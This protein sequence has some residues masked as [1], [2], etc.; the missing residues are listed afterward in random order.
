MYKM[1]CTLFWKIVGSKKQRVSLSVLISGPPHLSNGNSCGQSSAILYLFYVDT[2]TCFDQIWSSSEGAFYINTT[3]KPLINIATFPFSFMPR[4]LIYIYIYI[5][6]YILPSFLCKI[7]KLWHLLS[8]FNLYIKLNNVWVALYVGG[9]V[10]LS[11][12]WSSWLCNYIMGISC[13][14][15]TKFI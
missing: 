1:L 5:Y 14:Y 10:L 2:L 7:A 11:L 13:L 12:G 4:V 6:I 8:A 3:W 15:L 9:L